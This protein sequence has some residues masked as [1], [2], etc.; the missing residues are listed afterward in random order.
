MEHVGSEFAP[1][2]NKRS[3]ELAPDITIHFERDP[4][5]IEIALQHRSSIIE[6]MR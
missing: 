5:V 6:W 4:R 3:H 1:L 2:I